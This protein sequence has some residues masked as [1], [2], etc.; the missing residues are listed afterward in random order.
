ML[1][2]EEICFMKSPSMREDWVLMTSYI[3]DR[4][5]SYVIRHTQSNAL[6]A[7]IIEHMC[8]MTGLFSLSR[9]LKVALSSLRNDG[10]VFD[11]AHAPY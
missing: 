8:V 3:P 2:R 7:S 11:R 10:Y 4:R 1:E 5:S 9:A 6:A